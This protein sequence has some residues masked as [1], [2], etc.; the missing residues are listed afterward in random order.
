MLRKE[1]KELL[2]Y[3]GDTQEI[4][5]GFTKLI[6]GAMREIKGMHFSVTECADF[7]FPLVRDC[8]V[9][10]CDGKFFIIP[11]KTLKNNEDVS[12]GLSN[13]SL[14][15]TEICFLVEELKGIP[16]HWASVIVN[17]DYFIDKIIYI[18]IRFNLLVEHF[19][20]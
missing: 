9:T 15:T 2:E 7:I 11:K 1:W 6:S 3:H 5:G 4:A 8:H 12:W 18:H 16:Q 13:F 14:K 10:L 20:T 17:G 19:L